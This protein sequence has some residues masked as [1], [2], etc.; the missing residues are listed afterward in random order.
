MGVVRQKIP[1]GL[2]CFFLCAAF[3][4]SLPIAVLGKEQETTSTE[5]VQDKGVLLRRKADELLGHVRMI[6][7][8]QE[9]ED[10]FSYYVDLTRYIEA[11]KKVLLEE[12]GYVTKQQ[13]QNWCFC[14]AGFDDYRPCFYQHRDIQACLSVLQREKSKDKINEALTHLEQELQKAADDSMSAAKGANKNAAFWIDA[15]LRRNGCPNVTSMIQTYRNTDN[16][17][18]INAFIQCWSSGEFYPQN[19]FNVN[20][21]LECVLYMIL[22]ER[23]NFAATFGGCDGILGLCKG[24]AYCFAPDYIREITPVVHKHFAGDEAMSSFLRHRLSPNNRLTI[25]MFIF[26][27]EAKG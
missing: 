26:P 23:A 8:R 11:W 15:W 22:S 16:A 1:F 19:S 21:K 17:E 3:L 14:G 10:A 20:D 5:T 25:C 4:C 27:I 2:K 13:E 18:Q 7:E 9:T 12:S 6:R 24:R